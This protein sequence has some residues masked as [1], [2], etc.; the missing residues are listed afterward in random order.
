[1]MKM[2]TAA[3]TI[4]A[5]LALAAPCY[6][7]V[8]VQPRAT[9][10]PV[11]APDPARLAAARPVIEKVWPLGTYRRM[12]DG[13]MGTIMDATLGSMFDMKASDLAGMAGD[14]Q[15]GAA[16]GDRTIGEL[17]GSRDP[18][19]RERMKITMD[20]MMGDMVGLMTKV[21]P[22][23]RTALTAAY[24]RQFDVA[25][26]AELDRFFATP[27][28]AV[29]ARESMLLFAS[30]EMTKAMQAFTPEL[31]RAMPGIM[32]K[33]GKATAHLPAPP[34]PAAE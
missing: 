24:A 31:M 30:P 1:M 11:P 15:A 33:V 28:G 14:A 8:P 34:K 23:V 9:V 32:A 25:Q 4:A 6:A 7:Q 2:A 21:E 10:I 3:M 16:A 27:T 18:H 5:M 12:M 20:V 19:V 17:A 29:Y 26:L 22:Q 13:M